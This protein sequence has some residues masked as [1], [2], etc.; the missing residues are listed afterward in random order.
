MKDRQQLPIGVFDSGLGG[1]TVVK[2]LNKLL[3]QE[4]IIYV[5]D[6][7]RV[8]YG[9][10]S[11]E[12]IR[13]Y[14]LQISFFLIQKKVKALVVACNS[15]SA[16]ALAALKDLP[17]PVVGVIDP[18]ARAAVLSTTRGRV[19][20]IGTRA[21][22]LSQAYSRAL[23]RYSNSVQVWEKYCPLFVP[24]VEEGWTH[25]PVTLSVAHE[26]LSPLLKHKIDTLV[27]GCTHYPLLKGLLQSVVGQKVKLI[28]SADETAKDVLTLLRKNNLLKPVSKKKQLQFFVT[29][30]PLS[31]RRHG[32]KFFGHALPA[33]RLLRFDSL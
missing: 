9:T 16:V 19:A 24:L 3:P 27:L 13:K 31:F 28:D 1:L 4:D 6:T 2:A 20:V 14:A 10:K 23:R 12:T 15:V 7:A 21:T 30:N 29:D 18:G 25:H 17:I 26:Y 5:G 22:V 32:E 11:P 33:A 8:P